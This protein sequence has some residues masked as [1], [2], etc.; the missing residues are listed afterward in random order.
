MDL[1][2][3]VQTLAQDQS[4]QTKSNWEKDVLKF[5]SLSH[6]TRVSP[7]REA[8]STPELSSSRTRGDRATYSPRL[9]TIFSGSS[10]SL[11][12]GAAEDKVRSL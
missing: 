11:F 7:G 1:N 4:P 6:H 3:Q 2:Q 9:D 5:Q 10:L 8:G 12:E